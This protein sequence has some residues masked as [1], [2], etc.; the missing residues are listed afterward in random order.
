MKRSL[1]EEFGITV[2]LPLSVERRHQ[3]RR[4]MLMRRT[5]IVVLLILG[6]AAVAIGLYRPA[7]AAL[8]ARVDSRGQCVA[9]NAGVD[10]HR[11]L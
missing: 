9:Q 8:A 10:Q 2:T 11:E 1:R 6:A 3:A 5:A 7:R 4:Q